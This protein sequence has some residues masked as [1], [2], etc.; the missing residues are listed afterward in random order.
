MAEAAWDR[1]E[2]CDHV[3]LLADDDP[4]HLQAL[5]DRLGRSLGRLRVSALGRYPRFKIVPVRD[6]EEALL[7]AS[8]EVS[9]AALDL[10][11]PH[12]NGIEVIQELRSRRPDMAILA[13]TA[14][15]PPSEAVAAI[16]AGADHFHE[17][18]DIESFEHAVELAIDRRRLTRLIEHN[19]AEV[20]E[21]RQRLQRLTGQLGP[22]LPGLRPPQTSEA[23]IPLDEAVGRYLQAA[24]RIFEGDPQ[25]MAKKLG[26][27]YFALRRL[28]KRH[29]VA[30]PGRTHRQGS[31]KG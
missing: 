26:I 29:D 25:G 24:A 18:S 20:D 10:V 6:G 15:A 21:A 27:S 11:M 7:K 16:M 8:A 1:P 14:G 13:F 3:L 2:E 9:V 28:L 12:R 31:R 17:Y 23:V 4:A 19:E 30:F 5:C 22:S